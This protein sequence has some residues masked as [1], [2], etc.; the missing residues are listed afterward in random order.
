VITLDVTGRSELARTPLGGTPASLLVLQGGRVLVAVRDRARVDVLDASADPAQPLVRRGSVSAA[1]EPVAL[2]VTP[3]GGSV[4]IASRWGHALGVY[5]AGSLERRLEVDLP[6]DPAAVVASADGRKAFVTHLVGSRM[7]V[8]DLASDAAASV[9]R[10]DLTF[11][12]EREVHT[13]SKKARVEPLRT[14]RHMHHAGQSWSLLQAASG[15]I[16]A[17]LV[18]ADPGNG[19]LS[20]GY[21]DGRTVAGDVA[22]IDPGAEA[23]VAP[24]TFANLGHMDCLLP[25]AAALD[26]ERRTLLVACVGLD[27]VVE[28]DQGGNPHA[29]ERRRIRVGAGPTGIAVDPASRTAVVWSELDHAA[30]FIALDTPAAAKVSPVILPLVRRARQD[31]EIARGRALFYAVSSQRIAA[32]GRACAS[33][34]PD[35]RDDGLTWTT[36]EGPRQTPILAERLEGTSPYGW[37]G[38]RASLSDHLERTLARLSGTGIHKE[39]QA[40]LLAYVTTLRAPATEARDTPEVARGAAIFHSRAAACS[41]CHLGDETFTDR[42]RHDVKSQRRGDPTAAFDTPSLRFVGHSAPFFH[43]GRYA[44]LADLVAGSDG[45]MGHTR[46]LSV[47]ER[48]ALVAYLESL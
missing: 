48:S 45:T 6:R 19:V 35:G 23:R 3:D 42:M 30:T 17:P 15:E 16:V 22:V 10:I 4:L 41:S 33:C 44:T 18:L 31:V 27:H 39:E 29:H 11:N 40:A 9:R 46:H 38:G 1:V 34:H 43:D 32:D 36:P 2:A 13:W 7:S 28:Y 14:E 47:E 5:D 21:G 20:V 8:V 37:D 26:E 12:E 25:R 24:R